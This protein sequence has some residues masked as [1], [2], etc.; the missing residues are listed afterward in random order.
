M[1]VCQWRFNEMDRLQVWQTQAGES[2]ST[3]SNYLNIGLNI[4]GINVLNRK[5]NRVFDLIK[6]PVIRV[7]LSS[8]NQAVHRSTIYPSGN[9]EN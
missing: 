4:Y 1:K 3:V 5:S 6:I 7:L 8:P 9:K 2:T